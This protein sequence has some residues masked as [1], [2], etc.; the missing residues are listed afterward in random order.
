MNQ[1]NPK[2][3]IRNPNQT[4]SPKSEGRPRHARAARRGRLFGFR[5]CLLDSG[6]GFRVSDFSCLP[7]AILLLAL[8]ACPCPAASLKFDIV[9]KVG[10]GGDQAA[11]VPKAVEETYAYDAKTDTVTVTERF[12]RKGF[13]PVPPMLALAMD[14]GFHVRFDPKPMPLKDAGVL[15]PLVG[16]ENADSYTWSI[17]GLSRY[18]FERPVLGAEPAPAE[19]QM[20]VL[21]KALEAEVAKI[22]A[23]S[24]RGSS[25]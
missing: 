19:V 5:I 13:A 4:P 2:P 24:P 12:D 3:E 1:R 17:E 10:W 6:F 22:V 21:E 18:V 7:A 25:S 15:G 23:A 9:D 8:L 16:Y 11:N 14:Q 20:V